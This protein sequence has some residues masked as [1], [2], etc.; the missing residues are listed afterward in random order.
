MRWN[1]RVWETDRATRLDRMGS[2]AKWM[3]EHYHPLAPSHPLLPPSREQGLVWLRELVQVNCTSFFRAA[4]PSRSVSLA[5]ASPLPPPLY[6]RS[7]FLGKNP[8]KIQSCA[9]RASERTYL[10]PAHYAKI[11]S[12]DALT[13]K[14][15][16]YLFSAENLMARVKSDYYCVSCKI[17]RASRG[18]EFIRAPYQENSKLKFPI[19][20]LVIHYIFSITFFFYFLS[21]P[22]DLKSSSSLR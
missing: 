10:L 1:H 16:I 13:P 20:I 12:T 15:S 8:S 5:L 14:M 18:F 21:H 4:H 3:R 6:P 17:S 22:R 11:P 7:I 2:P 9:F 19:S